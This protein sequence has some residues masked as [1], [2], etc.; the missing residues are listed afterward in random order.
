MDKVTKTSF[1]EATKL[2]SIWNKI[3]EWNG[4]KLATVQ[5]HTDKEWKAVDTL[6]FNLISDWNDKSHIIVEKHTQEELWEYLKTNNFRI[7]KITN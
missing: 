2:N 4:L 5:W 1:R 6:D 7:N 3:V